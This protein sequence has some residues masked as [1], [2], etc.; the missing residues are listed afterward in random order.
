MTL[1]LF[2]Q[3]DRTYAPPEQDLDYLPRRVATRLLVTEIP[4]GLAGQLTAI[5][6]MARAVIEAGLIIPLMGRV[7]WS[8]IVEAGLAAGVLVRPGAGEGRGA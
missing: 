2:F 7:S 4:A 3:G 5:E 8:T 6:R 1:D